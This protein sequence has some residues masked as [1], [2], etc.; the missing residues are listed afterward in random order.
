MRARQILV[1][2]D[3]VYHGQN[4]LNKISRTKCLIQ[5]CNDTLCPGREQNTLN[6]MS[7]TKWPEQNV[8]TQN[9]QAHN[10]LEQ[11]VHIFCNIAND[12][13][14][15]FII[16]MIFFKSIFDSFYYISFAYYVHMQHTDTRG[17]V[18]TKI[19]YLIIV[20]R[21]NCHIKI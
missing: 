15:S 1:T 7:S 5:K 18:A 19:G 6:K 8:L 9:V 16:I 17:F 20:A 21:G 10:A 4:V 12:F 13:Q 14:K 3:E 2:F 11:N